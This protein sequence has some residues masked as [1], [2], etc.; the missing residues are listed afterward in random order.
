MS[1]QTIYSLIDELQDVVN[2]SPGKAFS[3]NK[4]VDVKLMNEII[5]DIRAAL[6]DEF[7]V[8]REIAEQK[9]EFVN[10]GKSQ[11]EDL[12]RQAEDALREA[13]TRSSA[14]LNEN[15]IVKAANDRAQ[16]IVENAKENAKNV[17]AS[18]LQYAEEVLFD[19]EDYFKE[20][21]EI[22]KSNRES[23][24]QKPV[25]QTQSQVQEPTN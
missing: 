9:D 2:K 19:V 7:A 11:A 21:I 4:V 16:K 1:N 24:Q 10:Q 6:E 23:L 8:S 15:N 22:V 25:P 20:Y 17:R 18:A 13:K 3:K 5:E 14:M 12:L